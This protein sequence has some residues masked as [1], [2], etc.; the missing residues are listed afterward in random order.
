[1]NT[2]SV[3]EVNKSRLNIGKMLARLIMLQSVLLAEN[4]RI[5]ALNDYRYVNS[6]T[7]LLEYSQVLNNSNFQQ[8]FYYQLFIP[9]TRVCSRLFILILEAY[10]IMHFFNTGRLRIPHE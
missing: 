6:L 2:I 10:V 1:M 4:V 9:Y 3:V 7:K 8:R 5:S